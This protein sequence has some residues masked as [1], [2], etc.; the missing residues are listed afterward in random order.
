MIR[1]GHKY[2]EAVILGTTLIRRDVV[3]PYQTRRYGNYRQSMTNSGYQDSN[4]Y[5]DFS[6]CKEALGTNSVNMGYG[7]VLAKTRGRLPGAIKLQLMLQQL[8]QLTS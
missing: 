5:G 2:N 3:I 8:M 6:A 1:G 7:A 4:L